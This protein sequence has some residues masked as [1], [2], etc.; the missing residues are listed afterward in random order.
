MQ[1]SNNDFD[2]YG[3]PIKT[4]ATKTFYMVTDL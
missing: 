1:F 4:F 2:L 3:F